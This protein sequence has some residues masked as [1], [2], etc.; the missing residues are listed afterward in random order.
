MKSNAQSV[1][2]FSPIGNYLPQ[3]YQ[4]DIPTVLQ[5]PHPDVEPQ[6][7]LVL[8]EP[9]NSVVEVWGKDVAKISTDSTKLYK[10]LN[11]WMWG[12]SGRKDVSAIVRR[13]I[14][15]NGYGFI[16]EE[17]DDWGDEDWE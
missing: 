5:V 8:D 4:L 17:D 10:A 2:N 16:I 9:V 15:S 6:V 1:R 13:H 11:D 7:V 3:Q 14:S 12:M